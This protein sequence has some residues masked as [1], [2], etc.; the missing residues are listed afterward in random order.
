MLRGYPLKIRSFKGL[1]LIQKL[2]HSPSNVWCVGTA[3]VQ[4]RPF[5][6]T[7][8]HIMLRTCRRAGKDDNEKGLDCCCFAEEEKRKPGQPKYLRVPRAWTSKIT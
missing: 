1:S 2:V 4:V 7:V 5:T 8:F 6:H 3:S